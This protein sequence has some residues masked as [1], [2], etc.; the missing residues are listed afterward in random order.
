MVWQPL[1]HRITA[2]NP[3]KKI[4]F[5][6]GVNIVRILRFV[7]LVLCKVVLGY[8]AAVTGGLTNRQVQE[9]TRSVQWGGFWR[10]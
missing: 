1:Q 4:S 6:F 7:D 3:R 8:L 10:P 2:G 9:I 5:G